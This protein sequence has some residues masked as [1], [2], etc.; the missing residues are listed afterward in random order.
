MQYVAKRKQHGVGAIFEYGIQKL[1]L[2]KLVC[3]KIYLLFMKTLLCWFR[4]KATPHFSHL[5][6][7]KFAT[8]FFLHHSWPMRKLIGPYFLWGTCCACPLFFFVTI[9]LSTLEL[10]PS[11]L[12]LYL[13]CTDIGQLRLG[14]WLD[15]ECF[16]VLF[17]AWLS[18][19]VYVYYIGA[20]YFNDDFL[21]SIPPLDFWNCCF[22]NVG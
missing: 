14:T 15:W 22:S 13:S 6:T 3:F 21:L 17:A 2:I 7:R 11:L 16:S 8:H 9:S 10:G 1:K 12:D 4:H 5:T 20:I 19:R 18:C